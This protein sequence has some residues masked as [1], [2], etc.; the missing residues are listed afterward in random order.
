MVVAYGGPF[1]FLREY[2][3]AVFPNRNF[4]MYDSLKILL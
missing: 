3:T 4:V 2:L 1:N